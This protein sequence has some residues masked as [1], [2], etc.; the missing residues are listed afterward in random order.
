MM[1]MMMGSVIWVSAA[2]CCSKAFEHLT[3]CSTS[4]ETASI[5]P[6]AAGRIQI[7]KRLV[8]FSA[9]YP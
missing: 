7:K 2:H 5:L 3:C 1:M 9:N 8:Y 4:A 6:T